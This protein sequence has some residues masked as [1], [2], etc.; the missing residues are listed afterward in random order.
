MA[1]DRTIAFIQKTEALFGKLLQTT[2]EIGVASKIAKTAKHVFERHRHIIR[3]RGYRPSTPW[4][5]M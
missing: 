5:C 3:V 1:E 2:P 4:P